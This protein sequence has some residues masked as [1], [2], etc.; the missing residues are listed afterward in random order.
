MEHK[1]II[2]I[3][4]SIL[5]ISIF[6]NIFIPLWLTRSDD[7]YHNYKFKYW[8]KNSKVLETIKNYVQEI[9]TKKNKNYIPK[10]DRIAV[11][12]MDGTILGEKAPTY[13]VWTF[14]RDTVKENSTLNNDPVQKEI[15]KKV[16]DY[17]KGLSTDEDLEIQEIKGE[18]KI[19]ENWTVKNYMEFIRKYLERNA[20]GFKNIK[21]K[22][23]YYKPMVEIIN[24][25]Q[26][27]FFKVYIVSGSE[28]FFVREVVSHFLDDMP[29]E[30]II[31]TD[32]HLVGKEENISKFDYDNLYHYDYTNSHTDYLIK[33][34]KVAEY[35]VKFTKVRLIAKEIGR[36]PVLSFGN[37]SGDAPMHNYVLDG[38]KYKSMAFMVVADDMKREYGIDIIKDDG[39]I[40]T[41][42][43]DNKKASWKDK[44]GKY[45]YEIIS[46]RDDFKTIY[47][48]DVTLD[49]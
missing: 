37:S 25:L 38:N 11:F 24:F 8:T 2:I 9:T 46:M 33:S 12:D 41:T 44:S 6:F 1:A 15:V 40:D 36:K 27:N 42:N 16:E 13:V 23:M 34:D 48:D 45:G 43:S 21:F 31:G 22:D 28:R 39:S 4:S 20:Y 35:N 14:Y 18:A 5:F 26:K 17:I 7:H 47:G 10:E 30:R 3:L 32:F 29:F 19:F 49:K